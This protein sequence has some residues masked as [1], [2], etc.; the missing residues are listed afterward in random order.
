MDSDAEGRA[1]VK[2]W[3]RKLTNCFSP[4]IEDSKALKGHATAPE[5][6]PGENTLALAS[7]LIAQLRMISKGDDSF[8]TSE[9]F[10]QFDPRVEFWNQECTIRGMMCSAMT[11]DTFRS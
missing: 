10:I 11:F 6:T 3:M 9:G 1:A 4:I 2:S 8:E 7:N 5:S